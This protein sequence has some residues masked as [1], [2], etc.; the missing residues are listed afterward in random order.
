MNFDV[1]HCQINNFNSGLNIWKQALE[2][3]S[4]TLAVAVLRVKWIE[5]ICSWFFSY[6]KAPL[7]NTLIT[8]VQIQYRRNL[9][10]CF[11]MQYLLVSW[12]IKKAME[13]VTF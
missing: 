13:T 10:K 12:L 11:I 7:P 8:V 6:P 2:I 4:K 3:V 1:A 9:K 5:W